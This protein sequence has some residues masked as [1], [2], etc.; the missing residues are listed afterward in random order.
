MSPSSKSRQRGTTLTELLTVT[1]ILGLFLTLA[2]GI[3]APVLGA[4]A[5]LQAKADTLQSA[6]S[7]YYRLQRDVRASDIGGD[8]AC[9]TTGT[10]TCTQTASTMTS[11]P[12]LAI[13][14]P[15][16]GS[17][18]V[19]SST[20][21]KPTWQGVTVYWIATVSGRTNL[22]RAYVAFGSAIQAPTEP[23][24]AQVQSAVTTAVGTSGP[25]ID[26][27][28][29]SSLSADFNATSNVLGLKVSVA[30]SEGGR[31]NETSFESD[32]Y[33]RN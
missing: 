25:S 29:A 8:Y 16:S 21:G 30:A 5:R 23:T 22:Y 18:F 31:T 12:A 24:A 6:A 26:M 3:I 13:V 28:N 27:A 33:A 9:T 4:P 2:L 7:G 10:I 19:S 11:T 20:T 17:N 14:T 15:M 1:T 32:T